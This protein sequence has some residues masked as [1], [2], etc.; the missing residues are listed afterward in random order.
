MFRDGTGRNLNAVDHRP[1]GPG[2]EKYHRDQRAAAIW[3][4]HGDPSGLNG[5]FLVVSGDECPGPAPDCLW[6]WKGNQ[7]GG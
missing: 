6:H 4:V 5:R 1:T 3:P 7:R 2:S